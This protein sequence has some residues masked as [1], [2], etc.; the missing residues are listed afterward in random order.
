MSDTDYHG[1]EY[2]EGVEATAAPAAPQAA[3][4]GPVRQG[5]TGGTFGRVIILG[6]YG[7]LCAS[8]QTLEFRNIT[9]AQARKLK[10]DYFGLCHSVM[11]CYGQGGDVVHEE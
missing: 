3:H 8:S 10:W 6:N 1:Q 5:G 4:D 11:T 9:L 7:A 2:Q